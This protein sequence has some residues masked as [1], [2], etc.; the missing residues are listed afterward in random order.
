M[1]SDTRS[2]KI[3]LK[4]LAILSH[5]RHPNIVLC[6]VVDS[7][8]ELFQAARVGNTVDALLEHTRF[9]SWRYALGILDQQSVLDF[10]EECYK[11][12]DPQLESIVD[13]I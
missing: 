5:L 9:L 7:L 11:E 3:E 4:N 1:L 12:H 8:D 10:P 13:C 2:H 6:D